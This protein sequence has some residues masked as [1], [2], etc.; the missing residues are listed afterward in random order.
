MDLFWGVYFAWSFLVGALGAAGIGFWAYARERKTARQYQNK[1]FDSLIQRYSPAS[2]ADLLYL[3]ALFPADWE[4][5]L[6]QGALVGVW[7]GQ[8]VVLA[9]ARELRVPLPSPMRIARVQFRPGTLGEPRVLAI[10]YQVDGV[11]QRV[12]LSDTGRQP[13]GRKGGLKRIE[14]YLRASLSQAGAE[15]ESPRLMPE[16]WTKRL[17]VRGPIA[18]LILLVCIAAMEAFARAQGWH[19]R[20]WW[21][22]D[23]IVLL[24][25]GPPLWRWAIGYT[26]R[27]LSPRKQPTP[28]PEL[29]PE[30]PQAESIGDDRD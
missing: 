24:L 8:L 9:E 3:D 18:L 29:P 22:K 4:N 14:K 30:P 19:D 25:A 1:V 12:F 15:I 7:D 5:K 17:V 10:F 16:G 2:T 6:W 28:K 21:W 23:V 20:E 11:I 27:I 13:D 26:G